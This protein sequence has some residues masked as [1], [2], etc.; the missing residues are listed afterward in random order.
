MTYRRD[1]RQSFG[2]SSL[3]SWP[4]FPWSQRIFTNYFSK[5]KMLRT[6]FLEN[7]INIQLCSEPWWA[8]VIIIFLYSRIS[9]TATQCL[10]VQTSKPVFLSTKILR[11]FL[12]K[13][14]FW[15]KRHLWSLLN[16]FSVIF[17]AHN[18]FTRFF[19]I[20]TRDGSKKRV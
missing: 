3:S 14:D 4:V 1:W 10:Q 2:C 5:M 16:D 20:L 8:F 7:R 19:F 11:G 18:D 6:Y 17:F 12:L 15:S 13:R 9:S